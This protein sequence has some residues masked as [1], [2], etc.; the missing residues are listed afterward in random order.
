MVQFS[1]IF[2]PASFI[3]AQF[4][5]GALTSVSLARIMVMIAAAKRGLFGTIENTKRGMQA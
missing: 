2:R 4:Q 5:H 1:A 3:K